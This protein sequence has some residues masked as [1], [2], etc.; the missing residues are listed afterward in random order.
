MHYGLML[1][2][3]FVL[4]IPLGCARAPSRLVRA[5]EPARLSDQEQLAEIRSTAIPEHYRAQIETRVGAM[6]NTADYRITY[7][8]QPYGSLVCGLLTVRPSLG[9]AAGAQPLL[10]YFDR[11]G[12]LAALHL[13]PHSRLRLAPLTGDATATEQMPSLGSLEETLLRDCGFR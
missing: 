1:L 11:Q 5:G 10:A 9:G 3:L 13:Y 2:L 4:T 6:L 12:H 7:G 8:Q